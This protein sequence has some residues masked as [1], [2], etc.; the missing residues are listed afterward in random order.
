MIL[1]G[2]SFRG[3]GIL[4]FDAAL[5]PDP[6]PPVPVE[7]TL[8]HDCWLGP[9]GTRVRGYKT[10]RWRLIPGLE[11]FECPACFG[12]LS[13]QGDWFFH[14]HAVGSL[15]HLHL[16]ALPEFGAAFA[17]PHRPS[18]R[19]PS[20]RELTQRQPDHAHN[21]DDGLGGAGPMTG[22]ES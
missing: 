12:A 14:H 10:S 19:R 21:R 4:P 13:S 6:P 16:G 5:L 18:L 20:A 15:L 17:S 22:P 2:R 1:D 11:K 7:R 3:A 8:L 9:W